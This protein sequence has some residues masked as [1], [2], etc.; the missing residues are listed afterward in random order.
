MENCSQP[1]AE[2]TAG[3]SPWMVCSK[4][5]VYSPCLQHSAWFPCLTW[6]TLILLLF[7]YTT[8]VWTLSRF[9]TGGLF[10]TF[11]NILLQANLVLTAFPWTSAIV[12]CSLKGQTRRAH[13][14][15]DFPEPSCGNEG[16]PRKGPC[17]PEKQEDFGRCPAWVLPSYSGTPKTELR[18]DLSR[19]IF[20]WLEQKCL[21]HRSA[22]ARP[23]TV[24]FG[25]LLLSLSWFD[26]E[27]VLDDTANVFSWLHI[28]KGEAIQ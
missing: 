7:C 13:L 16:E 20:A 21:H 8:A 10:Q 23:K 3:S 9:N 14:L 1:T 27:D 18:A 28:R 22:D 12:C 26:R 24:C 6:A 4:F 15:V 2:E 11:A 17:L 19:H 25:Y 5:P